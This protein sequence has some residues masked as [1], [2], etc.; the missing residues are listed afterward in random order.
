MVRTI[1]PALFFDASWRQSVHHS[2][3]LSDMP[4][5]GNLDSVPCSRRSA[6]VQF[7]LFDT[8]LL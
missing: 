3:V 6:Q 2:T 4:Q 7:R 5:I 1:P 8:L